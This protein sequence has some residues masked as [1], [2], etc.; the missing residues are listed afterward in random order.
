[1]KRTEF[2][3]IWAQISHRTPIAIEKPEWCCI[4]TH[5]SFNSEE[6]F[7]YTYRDKCNFQWCFHPVLSGQWDWDL[8]P[9]LERLCN[10]VWASLVAQ[11]VKSLPAVW[12]TQVQPLGQE[13]PLEKEMATHSIFFL[14]GK[15][16]GRRN[17][18]GYSPWGDKESD[19]TK[20]LHSL[21][22]FFLS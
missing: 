1:M 6:N 20:W 16:H 5:K 13:E 19:M 17:L 10:R 18:A 2:L 3:R 14:P 11:M 7:K 15:S 4:Y 21:L 8:F 22:S 9:H 12:E